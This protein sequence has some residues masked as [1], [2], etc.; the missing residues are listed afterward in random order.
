MNL[1]ILLLLFY[2]F[3]III[4]LVKG[5]EVVFNLPKAFIF[6]NKISLRKKWKKTAPITHTRIK[7]Y[8][9]T[10]QYHAATDLKKG[11]SPEMI[12]SNVAKTHN[13]YHSGKQ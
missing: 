7:Q 6:V 4:I 13:G 3:I 11:T 2:Y 8:H 5:L 12:N 1:L 9:T 10:K